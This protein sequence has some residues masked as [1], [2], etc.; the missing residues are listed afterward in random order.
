[1]VPGAAV[2][3]GNRTWSFVAVPGVP[4]AV[5]VAGE[6]VRPALVAVRVF[7]PAAVPRVQL[8]TVAMP[9]LL[10]VVVAPVREPPPVATAK[11]TLTPETGALDASSTRTLGAMAT[12]VPA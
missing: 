10:V 6:P 4:V 1:V 5:K 9:E 7:G 3:P 2:W 11:V 12:A 8:P